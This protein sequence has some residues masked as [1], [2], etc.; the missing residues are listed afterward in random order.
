MLLVLKVQILTP[1][2]LRGSTLLGSDAGESIFEQ[3]SEGD[4]FGTIMTGHVKVLYNRRDVSNL[5]KGQAF[6]D[7]GLMTPG[8]RFTCFTG[9]KVKILTQKAAGMNQIRGASFRAEV[10]TYVILIPY[11]KFADHVKILGSKF[12]NAV[13]DYIRQSFSIGREN[14]SQY[15][16]AAKSIEIYFLEFMSRQ[17]GLLGL[18]NMVEI[19]NLAN[20]STYRKLKQ[21]EVLCKQGDLADS[22]Y[23]VLSG[24]ACV[25]INGKNVAYI[26]RGQELGELGLIANFSNTRTATIH[27]HFDF[28]VA[29]IKYE[30]FFYFFDMLQ[31][32]RAQKVA[33]FIA[34]CA[35]S[36][37]FSL[38]EW[39]KE[40]IGRGEPHN[41]DPSKETRRKSGAIG[42]IG[43]FFRGGSFRGK[44]SSHKKDEDAN[45]ATLTENNHA[46]NET[47]GGVGELQI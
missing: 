35:L 18:F 22:M 20:V 28:E 6:C 11:Q 31:S 15:G 27:A 37:Y 42:S 13:R 33:D 24:L 9:T 1:E 36:K 7:L 34:S 44:Q 14:W 29:E 40:A 12:E 30:D 10:R 23:I 3:N 38:S 32:K 8:T 45:L 5:I 4:E 46:R 2:E 19:R 39:K 41:V 47:P 17:S 25:I 26:T 21:N 16:N 43:D